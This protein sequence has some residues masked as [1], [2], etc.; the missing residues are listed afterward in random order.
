[1]GV[2]FYTFHYLLWAISRLF[3]VVYEY[4]NVDTGGIKLKPLFKLDQ[5]QQSDFEY[6]YKFAVFLENQNE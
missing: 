1:M 3:A 4:G 2:A 6:S 5:Q